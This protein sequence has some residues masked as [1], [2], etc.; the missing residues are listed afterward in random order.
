MVPSKVLLLI[1][2]MCGNIVV[3]AMHSDQGACDAADGGQC[4][5]DHKANGYEDDTM[6]ALQLQKKVATSE[7]EGLEDGGDRL[8]ARA[9]QLQS[10]QG[11][12]DAIRKSSS[13]PIE[14][15]MAEICDSVYTPKSTKDWNLMWKRKVTSDTGGDE[16][17]VGIYDKVIGGKQYCTIAFAGSNSGLDFISNLD[18]R[19]TDYCGVVNYGLHKG[20]TNELNNLWPV[21]TKALKGIVE[22]AKCGGGL[23]I[24]GH[25][26]GGAL[27][28]IFPA[29]LHASWEH[30]P[31]PEIQGIYTLAAP[32]VSKKQ[33]TDQSAAGVERGG[34][35]PGARF[36]NQDINVGDLVPAVTRTLGYVH[37]KLEAVRLRERSSFWEDDEEHKS[38]AYACDSTQAMKKPT[39]IKVP[40]VSAHKSTE[41]IKRIKEM[42]GK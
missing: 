37:P 17:I 31:L 39:K 4:A 3:N 23:Y 14:L 20:F 1:G 8:T 35:F 34:C 7:N 5:N 28:H 16:D 40:K 32:G 27:A 41:H 19:T 21:V 26:L 24:V 9:E 33:L 25:S 13:D 2:M 30:G 36:F 22:E 42:F 6:A 10:V 18:A 12:L 15:Q 29:C 11:Y 38:K